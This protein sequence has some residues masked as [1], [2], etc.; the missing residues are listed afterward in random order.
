MLFCPKEILFVCDWDRLLLRWSWVGERKW[1]RT[2]R[3]RK[4]ELLQNLKTE[5][6]AKESEVGQR[7]RENGGEAAPVAS[8]DLKL[9]QLVQIIGRPTRATDLGKLEGQTNRHNRH[10][11]T[12]TDTT[13][14][15]TGISSNKRAPNQ[16]D[17]HNLILGKLERH[18]NRHRGQID[19]HNRQINRH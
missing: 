17:R 2:V 1:S 7:G 18:T 11:D 12:S 9:R 5:N 10:R 16:S 13:D 4:R 15:S 19:R 14:N 8:S 6:L 3:E